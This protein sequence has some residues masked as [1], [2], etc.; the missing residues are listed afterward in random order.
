MRLPGAPTDQLVEAWQ[1]YRQQS[2]LEEQ[3]G[4]F[5]SEGNSRRRVPGTAAN[6]T[7]PPTGFGAQPAAVKLRSTSADAAG[8]VAAPLDQ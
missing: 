2:R 7:K 6:R 3:S 5:A 1:D 4:Q 8:G